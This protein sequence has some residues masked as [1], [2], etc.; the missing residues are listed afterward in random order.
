MLCCAACLAALCGKLVIVAGSDKLTVGSRIQRSV[1]PL[2]GELIRFAERR[3]TGIMSKA[4]SIAILALIGHAFL[5]FAGISQAAIVKLVGTVAV[6]GD[7][8]KPVDF[9]LLVEYEPELRGAAQQF[10]AL[11]V[12]GAFSEVQYDSNRRLL[13]LR[14]GRS[15]LREADLVIDWDLA[16][17]VLASGRGT[18]PVSLSGVGIGEG[19]WSELQGAVFVGPRLHAPEPSSVGLLAA[20]VAGCAWYALRARRRMPQAKLTAA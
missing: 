18:F 19:G 6:E 9:D 4:S 12:S 3:Q 2:A 17:V 13:T 16:D 20:A 7:T 11:S 15:G 5:P 14:G 10:H 1:R 8:N